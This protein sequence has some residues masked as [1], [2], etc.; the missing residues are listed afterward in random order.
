MLTQPTKEEI[1]HRTL[2]LLVGLIALTLGPLTSFFA[3]ADLKI[4]SIS[5]SYYVD[6]WSQSILI[7]FLFAIATFLL[8]YN[9]KSRTEMLLSK[10]AAVAALCVA[11]FPCGCDDRAEKV[12]HV[13]FASAAVMFLVLVYFCY[14]FYRRARDKGHTE[15]K[16][17]AVVYAL[18]GLVIIASIAAMVFDTLAGEVLSKNSRFIFYCEQAGLAAFGFS[19]LT[20]SRI[21]P[22]F[23]RR[24]ERFSPW[25]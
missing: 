12:P 18:C 24:D 7:G 17:R 3:P 23:T 10:V 14:A 9:G 16:R 25:G 8:A 21:F 13:H 15:A 22:F 2:K 19:W 1:D 20:A 11:L 5:A 6:G 4:T